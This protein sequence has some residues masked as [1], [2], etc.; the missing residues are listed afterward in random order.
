MY[1]SK[2]DDKVG[3]QAGRGIC[4]RDEE[5][6]PDNFQGCFL[7]VTSISQSAR[8]SFALYR[9]QSPSEIWRVQGAK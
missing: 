9:T 4:E 1:E 7:P 3:F 6:Q 2:I 8:V 5:R